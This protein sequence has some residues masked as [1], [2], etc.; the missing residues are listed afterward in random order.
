MGLLN[1][2]FRD[3]ES[4]LDRCDDVSCNRHPIALEPGHDLH[5]HI[6]VCAVIDTEA[7]VVRQGHF[8]PPTIKFSYRQTRQQISL[9][10]GPLCQRGATLAQYPAPL[11]VALQN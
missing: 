7:D 1:D 2:A 4:R 6:S 10:P 5:D 11:P 3:S 9:G 8:A